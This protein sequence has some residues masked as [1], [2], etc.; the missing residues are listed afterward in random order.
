MFPVSSNSGSS[1]LPVGAAFWMPKPSEITEEGFGFFRD[2]WPITGISAG[3]ADD[4][5]STE[6]SIADVV[7]ALADDEDDFERLAVI[8]E[9]GGIDDPANEISDREHALLSEVVSDIPDLEGLE[10]GVAGLAYALA[11]V[12]ILPAAS[13][14]SHTERTWSDAPVVLFAST[15]YRARALQPLVEESACTFAIDQARPELLVVRG[16]S[17]ENTMALAKLISENRKTFVQPRGSKTP[18]PKPSS[19]QDALF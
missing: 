4:I 12:R 9:S 17:I 10:L 6:R 19:I 3:Y 7:N 1:E 2:T 14:R 16:S 5:V 15:D 18:H 11:S 13:C 8:A